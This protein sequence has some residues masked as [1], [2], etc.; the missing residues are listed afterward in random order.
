MTSKIEPFRNDTVVT[1]EEIKLLWVDAVPYVELKQLQEHREHIIELLR[2]KDKTP[3]PQ[4]PQPSIYLEDYIEHLRYRY[5]KVQQLHK[6]ENLHGG[7][8]KLSNIEFALT[9]ARNYLGRKE[10][11]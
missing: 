2:P 9:S 4:P 1:R 7:S 5:H 11:T 8:E 6:D 10:A 3:Q